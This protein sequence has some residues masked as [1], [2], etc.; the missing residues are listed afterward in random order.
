MT[1]VKICGV[2]SVEDAALALEAGADAI[3]LNFYPPSPR[4]ISVEKAAAIRA[5]IPAGVPVSGVFVNVDPEEIVAVS[6]RVGFDIAQLHGDESPAAVAQVARSLPV[7][8]A[9]QVGADFAANELEKY[10]DATGFL[11]EAAYLAPGQYG[12]SGRLADWCVATQIARGY[13]I[14][15]AG[16]LNS[17]N[18]ARA[19]EQVRP[20][21]VD[22]ATG[23]EVIT[24]KKDRT[25]L[26]DFLREVR[27]ADQEVRVP[28]EKLRAT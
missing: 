10:S 7:W 22:V 2:T 16:G 13:K 12:G 15:L 18:V 26:F 23:V 14:M 17:D 28:S 24:G 9:F 27:R 11:L 3:G 20:Y 5:T 21:A 19:V 1:H 6:R 8:K 4:F 25:R